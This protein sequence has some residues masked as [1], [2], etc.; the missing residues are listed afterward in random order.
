MRV[1]KC[2]KTKKKKKKPQT[3]FSYTKPENVPYI[4]CLIGKNDLKPVALLG[5]IL[6]YFLK[7]MT[8]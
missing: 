1:H 6:K 2:L 4:Y 7:F 8:L 5:T 3:G